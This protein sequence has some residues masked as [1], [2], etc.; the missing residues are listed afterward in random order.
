MMKNKNILIIGPKSK[1]GITFVINTLRNGELSNRSVFLSSYIDGGI[2]LNLFYYSIFLIKLFFI[3]VFNQDIK[4]LHIHFSKKGS[5]LRK[6]IVILISKLFNKKIIIHLHASEFHLFY[7]NTL[8]TVQKYISFI[9][10]ISD[11][12][13]VLS[14][15][16]Q[17]YICSICSNKDIQVLYNPLIMNEKAIS[18]NEVPKF[19]FMGRLGRRKGA[20]DIIEACKLIENKNFEIHLYGDGELEKLQQLTKEADLEANIK[21]RGWISSEE[22]D[23]AFK[24]ADVLLLPS[25]NEGLPISVLEGMSYGLPILSTPV[26]GTSEAVE[27]GVNGF[28]VKPGDVKALAEKMQLLAN[29]KDLRE[30]MGNESYK[31]AQEKF[32]VNIILNQLNVIYDD[33]LNK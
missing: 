29:D 11:K 9:L 32:D 12:I 14:S 17:D 7:Q 3:L 30:K 1:G 5:F 19:L 23:N 28:L 4:T 21:F 6:S 27:D 15:N 8:K 16:W 24:G 13:L 20:Y 31:I 22:K 33:L 25:Y 10:D 18:N 26:G 2:L